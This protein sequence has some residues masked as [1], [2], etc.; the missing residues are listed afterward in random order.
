[1]LRSTKS[2]Q[3]LVRMFHF[4]VNNTAGTITLEGLDQN[5]ATLVDNGTGDY[6]ITFSDAFAQ[7]PTAQ[8]TPAEAD[9]HANIHAISATAIQIKVW[10]LATGATPTDGDVHLTVVGSDIASNY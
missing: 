3:R 7:V 4:I 9:I 8:L 10:D 5:Q 6:T 1:M 2:P